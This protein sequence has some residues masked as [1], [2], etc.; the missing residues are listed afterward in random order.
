MLGAGHPL[1]IFT[2]NARLDAPPGVVVR[3]AREI[4]QPRADLERA[5]RWALIS[6]IFR[7]EGLLAGAG[8]WIDLDVLLLRSLS[9]MGEYVFGWQDCHVVNG[10]ILHLPAGS[11]CLLTLMAL[12]RADVVVAP[13]WSRSRKAMQRVLS[14]VGKHDPVE[15]LEW[16]VVGPLAITR[17]IADERL[18][19]LCQPM[20]VFYPLPWQRAELAFDPDA[21]LVERTLTSSTRAVHLWNDRIKAFKNSPPPRGSFIDTMHHRL[22]VRAAA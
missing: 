11:S 4:M 6:D 17:V 21:S 10:A 8:T 18:T 14:V 1:D 22:G 7:Y 20:D 2:Y 3:D 5:G 19:H 15:K 16:G 12:G 9:G 13:Q